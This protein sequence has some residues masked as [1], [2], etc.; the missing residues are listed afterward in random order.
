MSEDL[1]AAVKLDELDDGRMGPGGPGGQ[2]AM[3]GGNGKAFAFAF[4]NGGGADVRKKVVI[5]GPEGTRVYEG[6]AADDVLV[7]R[8][9]AFDDGFDVDVEVGP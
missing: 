9:F 5:A 6:D 2:G 3:M 4:P 1:N 8:D 7:E